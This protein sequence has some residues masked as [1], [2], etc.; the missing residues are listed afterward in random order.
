VGKDSTE[1]A[2]PWRKKTGS[3]FRKI[4]VLSGIQAVFPEM[5]PQKRA[6]I[7]AKVSPPRYR[8][9]RL[10]LVRGST[11]Y[12]EWGFEWRWKCPGSPD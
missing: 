12:K 10:T 4:V 7:D 9:H 1:Y 3:R 11:M 2:R 8:T 5:A 6:N